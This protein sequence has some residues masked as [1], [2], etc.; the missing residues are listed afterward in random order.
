MS[1]KEQVALGDQ[2]VFCG[3]CQGRRVGSAKPQPRWR[4]ESNSRGMP[5]TLRRKFVGNPVPM[6]KVKQVTYAS[7]ENTYDPALEFNPDMVGRSIAWLPRSHVET[8]LQEKKILDFSAHTLEA[9][10]IRGPEVSVQGFG[11]ER[12]SSGG[13]RKLRGRGTTKDAKVGASRALL[14]RT[15][16]TEQELAILAR[17]QKREMLRSLERCSVQAQ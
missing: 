12:G 17:L 8:W 6:R 11:H 14:Q 15:K 4:R 7:E 2:P 10:V 13:A 1:D 9:D 5:K 16:P 3:K